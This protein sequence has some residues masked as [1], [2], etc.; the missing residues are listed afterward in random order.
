MHEAK[1]DTDTP[2]RHRTGRV[3]VERHAPPGAAA[4]M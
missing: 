1:I 2:L 4:G 3:V